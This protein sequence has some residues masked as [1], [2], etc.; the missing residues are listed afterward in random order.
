[1]SKLFITGDLHGELDVSKLSHKHFDY[2]GL[3][4]DD[5]IIICGDFGF[6][7]YGNKKDNWW[8]NWLAEL[9][10]T[11]LWVDGNHENFEALSNYPVEGWHGGKVHKIRENVLHLMR[12]QVFD[13]NGQT[14]FTMGGASSHDKETRKEGISWWPQELPNHDE[15]TEALKKM[16]EVGWKVDYIISHCC[17]TSLQNKFSSY[18]GDTLT[19]FFNVLDKFT[20][21]KHWY[22]G[23]YHFSSSIDEKHTCL[24][25]EI[26]RIE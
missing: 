22:F 16:E 15:Y 11:I 18:D 20:T 19:D 5:Y 6:I 7:W 12:C 23:H 24:Y 26:K 1:M 4:K 3:T 17:S 2:T 25:H 21:F 10:C 8:L 13:I 9:P 14:F